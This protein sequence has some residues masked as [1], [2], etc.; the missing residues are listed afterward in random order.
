MQIA[1]LKDLTSKGLKKD[2]NELWKM[3][4]DQFKQ[5]KDELMADSQKKKQSDEDPKT[6]EKTLNE[7]LELM[8][9]MA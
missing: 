3:L 5:Y 1:A 7:S 8:T 6:R 4:D 2:K 9:N